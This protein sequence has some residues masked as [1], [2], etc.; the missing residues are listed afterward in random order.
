MHKK[1]NE[2][3]YFNVQLIKCLIKNKSRKDFIIKIFIIINYSI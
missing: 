1:S 2:V 3:F